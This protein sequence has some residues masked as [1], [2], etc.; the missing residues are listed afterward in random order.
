M[1]VGGL[2]AARTCEFRSPAIAQRKHR[3]R[4]LWK[5]FANALDLEELVASLGKIGFG[6][7]FVA[8]P[9]QSVENIPCK[10]DPPRPVA[11]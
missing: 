1:S 10:H 7:Y 6:T 5:S 4:Y 9:I 11:F 2:R 3:P 8:A